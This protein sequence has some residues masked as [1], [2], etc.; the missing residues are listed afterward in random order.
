[1]PRRSESREREWTSFC[2][3]LGRMGRL[4]HPRKQASGAYA[5]V[6]PRLH[7]L[8]DLVIGDR[9]VTLAIGDVKASDVDKPG[10]LSWADVSVRSY[11][12]TLHLNHKGTKAHI[13]DAVAAV[14]AALRRIG[15]RV[16]YHDLIRHEN[17]N[18]YLAILQVPGAW[19]EPGLAR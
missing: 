18:G 8:L 2:R 3:V 4:L 15:R 17:Q 13:Q 1:M 16:S 10:V 5:P 11:G 9:G 6:K 7:P 14:I 12:S 19:A